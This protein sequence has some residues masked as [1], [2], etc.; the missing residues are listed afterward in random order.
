M[1]CY[2]HGWKF[3]DRR[4]FKEFEGNNIFDP[5]K[6]Q[7][8]WAASGQNFALILAVCQIYEQICIWANIYGKYMG[9]F[10]HGKYVERC[11]SITTGGCYQ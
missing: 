6:R 7:I 11:A 8:F 1:K 9:K 2:V 5:V 10:I 4:L 3:M